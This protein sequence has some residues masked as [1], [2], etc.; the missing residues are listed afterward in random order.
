[1]VFH[2][3]LLVHKGEV[4][5]PIKVSICSHINS[6]ERNNEARNVPQMNIVKLSD[7]MK[8]LIV[9][10]FQAHSHFEYFILNSFSISLLMNSEIITGMI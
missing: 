4:I 1:M 6:P 9:C 2:S 5:A 8:N 10:Y 3:Y 7:G